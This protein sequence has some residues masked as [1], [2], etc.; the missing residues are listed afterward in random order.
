MGSA[1]TVRLPSAGARLSQADPARL[2][3]KER[4]TTWSRQP[5]SVLG[6][7]RLP[8]STG[9]AMS[10]AGSPRARPGQMHVIYVTSVETHS[11]PYVSP[12]AQPHAECFAV[13]NAP[14]RLH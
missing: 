6:S 3:R 7:N 12:M 10:N 5:P 1:P 11:T 4:S 2:S 13:I 9:C 8:R 14:R